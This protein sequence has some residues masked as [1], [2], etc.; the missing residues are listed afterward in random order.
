LI[1]EISKPVKE[2]NDA[3]MQ[4]LGNYKEGRMRFR[5]P[6]TGL[7]SRM[8]VDGIIEPMELAHMPYKNGRTYED[9]VGVRGFKRLGRKKWEQHVVKVVQQL[10][11]AL[12]P[13]DIVLGGGNVR[14]LRS[15]PL[16]VRLSSNASAF[17]GGFRMWQN[18]YLR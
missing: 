10:R 15:M 14:K 12:E 16:G 1:K 13:E 3:D 7:G 6:G 5:G 2:L 18:K 8:I 11:A 9:Y 17:V 4:A